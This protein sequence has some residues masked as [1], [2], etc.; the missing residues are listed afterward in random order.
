MLATALMLPLSDVA[1]RCNDEEVTRVL[2]PGASVA[3]SRE[4]AW[5]I[6]SVSAKVVREGSGMAHFLTSQWILN[7]LIGCP[8]FFCHKPMLLQ[9]VRLHQVWRNWDLTHAA[10]S[11]Q[12]ELIVLSASRQV[13]KELQS[14]VGR[15][16]S[17][18]RACS[19]GRR[20]CCWEDSRSMM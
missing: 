16:N 12:W 3:G 9:V 17:K 7:E 1:P 4:A 13:P 10:S 6:A 15:T 19:L 18:K 5:Y 8:A 14:K 11:M 20:R 2:Q